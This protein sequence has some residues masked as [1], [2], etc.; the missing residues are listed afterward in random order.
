MRNIIKMKTKIMCEE[1][2]A[3]CKLGYDYDGEEK[4]IPIYAECLKCGWSVC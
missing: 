4:P 2:G 3:K 1:C